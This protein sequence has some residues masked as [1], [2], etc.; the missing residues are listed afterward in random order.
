MTTTCSSTHEHPLDFVTHLR[1][2][3][4]A[5]PTDT[6]LIAVRGDSGAALDAPIDYRSLD[7][8]AR[9]LAARLQQDFAPGE[10]A[11]I[12]LDNG[13]DYVVSFFACLYAGLIAVPVF[14][15]ESARGQHL[16]RLAG[17]AADAQ[18]R[19][20]LTDT[21]TGALMG[22]GAG[23]AFREAV[24]LAVDETTT[25][26]AC[27]WAPRRP[28]E[29][30]IAFLQYTSGSTS[31]PKGVMV[32]H[33]NLMANMRAI[34]EGLCVGA[35]DVFA[36]WLPLNHD[37]GLIGGLLQPLHRGIPVALMSPRFFLERPVRW[38]EAIA[39]HRATISGGPDFAY[40][41]CLERVKPHQVAQ[42]DLSCW[43]LAFSGAEPVRAD[44]LRAFEAHFRPA[45]FRAEALYPCYGL[46]ESTLFVTGGRR[47]AGMAARRFSAKGIAQRMAVQAAH[48]GAE[49]AVELVGCGSTVCAHTLRIVDPATLEV[50]EDGHLGEIWAGGASIGAGYWNKPHES[51]VTFVERDG[52][53]WLRTGDLGFV[54]D[55]QLHVAGRIKDMIIVRGQNLYPQDVERAVEAEV[56]AVRKGRVA[57]FAVDG[58]D[59]EGIGLAAEVSR[60]MQKLVDPALL[61]EALGA[62]V[63]EQCG[64][65]LSVVLLLNPGALPKTT[66]GKLQRGAC[67]AGWLEGSIDAY[68]VHAHGRFT[69]GGSAPTRA[70]QRLDETESALAALWAEI[71]SPAGAIGPQAHFFTLGGNSLDAVQAAY[72][73]AA[74]WQVG[75][76]PRH[77]F[78]K[79]R[80][81]DCASELRRLVV[82][83]AQSPAAAIPVLTPAQRAECLPL[84]HAQQRQWFL[85][86]LDP[87]SAAY[88]VGGCLDLAGVLDEAALHDALEA[89]VQRHESLRTV[90]RQ[91]ADGSPR[92]HI[93]ARLPPRWSCIDLSGSPEAA[94]EERAVEAI[95][96]AQAEP[97]NLAAGPLVRALL[98][99][100][101]RGRHRLALVFHHIVT[102]GVSMRVVVEE[103]GVLYRAH[104][105]GEAPALP[106]LPLQYADY[107]AWH[108]EWLA[109]GER[110]RQLS[111]WTQR[112]G[113]EHPVLALPTDRPRPSVAGHL[114]GRLQAALP[115]TLAQALRRRAQAEGTTLFTVLL[116]GLQALLHRCTGQEDVRVGVPIANRQRGETAGLIGLFVN[117][118]VMRNAVRAR[119]PLAAVLAQAHTAALEAQSHPDLPFEQL[120]GALAPER[121]LAHSPLFQ[122][123]FNHLRED[124][125]AAAGGFTGL[126]VEVEPLDGVAAQFELS[127]EMGERPDGRLDLR[128]VYASE[129]FDALG[130]ERF[131]QRY[132]RM[133]QALAD[134]PA[135]PVGEV[136]LL[137]PGE[138]EDIAAWSHGP[139]E[140]IAPGP[141]HRRFE[142]QAAQ[143]PDAI[144]LRL[145]DVALGYGELNR[146]A[147]RLAHHLIAQGVGIEDRIG[148]AA[149]RSVEMVVGLLAILKAGGAYVPLD[150][151]LP[152]ERLATMVDDS[153]I[154]L[155]LTQAHLRERL[156]ARQ[157]LRV[158]A[159]ED[160]ALPAG[161]AEHDPRVPIDGENMVY[162]IYT[163]GSTGRP[164]G[165]ANRH[166]ALV[167]RIAWGQRH[168]PLAPGDTVLQKTPFSFDISFWEFFWPL[169][170]GATLALAAPH[171]HRDPAR[172]VALIHAHQVT[173]IHFVPSMLQAFLAHE[174]ARGCTGLARIVCS[175]EALPAELQARVFEKLPQVALLNLYGPTEAAIEVSAWD[176][177]EEGALTVPIGRPIANLEL[178]VLD[179]DLQP[180]PRGVAGELHLGGEGLARGY[181][182]RAGMTAERFVAS[183][184]GGGGRLYRSGDLVRWR[185]DG[186]IEYLGR[187]DHQVKIRGFRI[188]LGEVEARLLDQPGVCEAVVVAQQDAQGARLVAYVAGEALAADVLRRRLG[189]VLPDYMVPS[190]VMLLERLPLN[191]N[192]KVDRKA[193][194]PPE[195]VPTRPYE[196][197]RGEVAEA[198]AA[199]WSEVLGG[200]RIG[201]HDNFF[202]IGGHSLQLIRAHRLLEERLKA[203]L[204]VVDL[205]KHPSIAALTT[206]IAQGEAA[207][208]AASEDET[209]RARRQRAAL[210]Q[211]RPA[212]A[213]AS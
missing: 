156:P 162:L 6:A 109:R 194:P 18:A 49:E 111:Y 174:G 137:L 201:L 73:I 4:D 106:V 77:L 24:I 154:G 151:D 22:A 62:A 91:A 163:S 36:S 122:V 63:S 93:L 83:G 108:G 147:N 153:G 116:A 168:Q 27:L 150:P 159:L 145:D 82:E 80:L 204:T 10:R 117:T 89:L 35:E 20:V 142:R 171:D 134:Q 185:A 146:R 205:F 19:C 107:A 178:H 99:R 190:V 48:G 211:R 130:M 94:R 28:A 131:S 195:A 9:A 175:G 84:S 66:S 25:D 38:L 40:R 29:S 192:G 67:R 127:V 125:R 176:C 164:K 129:L 1:A 42:L 120:V 43:A 75:F 182:N 140:A 113:T 184:F 69:R 132:Q 209:E 96:Q 128:L 41:L 139:H 143:A 88:H 191:P 45:G 15:P 188:E 98:L 13:L 121:S 58:P 65:P 202:D 16:G 55:G 33:A 47:G 100:L 135:Q 187:V 158:L 177:R 32:S 172:L 101:A 208:A 50:L 104:A 210:M 196:A 199:I 11:L 118:Q 76:E 105:C 136:D 23:E 14:S 44:T 157:T 53:R 161:C 149:E 61:V 170:V 81:A 57:A 12:M 193:L 39:R 46:A 166:R 141:V 112:L 79:P 206:R 56:E 34:G 71:L 160:D 2:L 17:I 181:W 95:R 26:D 123:L 213:R 212:P 200:A 30:D 60:S 103:L 92:Q 52:L 64:E 72:R 110:E 78:D 87:S 74:R 169:S 54:F 165:A 90:F 51:A 5:R 189:A 173:T 102:D 180:A 167:N 148:I 31:A 68:A 186:Q 21:A 8:R 70:A 86:R 144:A 126:E 152:A 115:L 197:P 198:I 133:L 124:F 59:G 85:W 97:F 183:P 114:A 7:A 119:S 138:R 155:V 203:G 179:A 207:P 3:A 37:M